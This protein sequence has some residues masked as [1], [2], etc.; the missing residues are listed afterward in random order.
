MSSSEIDTI[1]FTRSEELL[2][3]NVAYDMDFKDGFTTLIDYRQKA[4]K[5]LIKEGRINGVERK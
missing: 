1:K 4:I 2:I 3:A 5:K